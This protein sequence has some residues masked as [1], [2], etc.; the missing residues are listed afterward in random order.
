MEDAICTWEKAIIPNVNQW[1]C[2]LQLDKRDEIKLDKPLT[3]VLSKMQIGRN[4]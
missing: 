4:E 2:L 1:Y 3:F